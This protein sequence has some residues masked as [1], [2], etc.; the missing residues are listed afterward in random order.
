MKLM[1][2][3]ALA[4]GL[5]AAPA[6]TAY[7][8]PPSQTCD[9]ADC[10]S[11]IN[12]GVEAGGPCLGGTRYVFGLDASGNTLICGFKQEWLPS[13]PLVGVRTNSSA[14]N[15]TGVAQSPDGIPMSCVGGHWKHDF[16]KSFY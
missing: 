1:A 14:C 4:G 5:I 12:R 6:A 3:L 16:N 8:A 13:P 11:Y 10:V 7:A 2:A 15:T 9:G